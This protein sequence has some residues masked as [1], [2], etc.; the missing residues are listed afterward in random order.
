M[1]YYVI[2]AGAIGKRHFENLSSLGADVA[3]V[4]WRGADL[5]G[6]TREIARSPS[7]LVIATATDVRRAL[8]SQAAETN[9]PIYVEKPLAFRQS[10][11]DEIYNIAKPIASRS[12]IGFM[13]RYH[14]IIREICSDPVRQLFRFS[15]EIGHDVRQWRQNWSFGESYAARPD[16]GGVL[17]DLCHELDLTHLLVPDARPERVD[18]CGHCQFPG[19]DFATQITLVDPIGAHGTVAMDYLSPDSIRR[20]H[21]RGLDQT[22]SIDLVK[23]T[24]QRSGIETQVHFDRNTMFVEIMRDFMQLAETGDQPQNPLAPVMDRVYDSCKN[25]TTAWEMRT[26]NGTI[27]RDMT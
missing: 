20:F 9:T 10:A 8:I 21:L 2:G 4:G 23:N 26:F 14:P 3:L 27:D 25:I 18:C 13:M 6:L 1:K 19:V 22:V 12:M 24:I 5:D 7:A 17:L 15:F 16:G 11:L